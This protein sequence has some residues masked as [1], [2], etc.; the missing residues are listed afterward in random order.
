MIRFYG[1]EPEIDIKI[2]TVG[3]RPGERL[4]ENLW[5]ASEKPVD[6]QYARIKEIETGQVLPFTPEIDM[7][8]LKEK[9]LPICRFDSA[10]PEIYRDTRLLRAI[11]REAVPTLLKHD[12]GMS[13]WSN[14]LFARD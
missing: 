5:A 12:E 7:D 10:N 4:G 2:E 1:Y 13:E 14:S 6:T 8:V 9:L 11:L 3:L